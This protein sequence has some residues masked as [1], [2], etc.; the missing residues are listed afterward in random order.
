MLVHLSSNCNA[1][2]LNGFYRAA[3]RALVLP[4]LLSYYCSYFC[5]LLPLPR[6]K[7]WKLWRQSEQSSGGCWRIPKRGWLQTN[8]SLVQCLAVA[9]C[10]RLLLR[11]EVGCLNFYAS[12]PMCMVRL[13]MLPL[14][15]LSICNVMRWD[16]QKWQ[17][18]FGASYEHWAEGVFRSDWTLL[19]GSVAWWGFQAVAAKRR[20]R[21]V[22]RQPSAGFCLKL[23][24]L[25][26]TFKFSN[27]DVS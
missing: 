17:M 14:S 1:P 16:F 24:L 21:A 5:L 8:K 13:I 11:C 18:F 25:S 20:N 7:C 10:D 12:F 15:V 26:L 6:K 2:M 23:F 22:H 3:Q 19:L 9:P 4:L 27:T